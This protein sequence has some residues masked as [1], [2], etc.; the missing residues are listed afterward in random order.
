MDYKL[1]FFRHA[2][3]SFSLRGPAETRNLIHNLCLINEIPAYAG[4][5]SPFK[6]LQKRFS[7]IF[8]P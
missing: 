7:L 3:R 8:N 4:M 2:W 6:P 5:T 1:Q